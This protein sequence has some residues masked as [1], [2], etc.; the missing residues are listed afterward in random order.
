M[1]GDAD[2][3]QKSRYSNGRMSVLALKEGY[4]DAAQTT[5]ESVG[6]GRQQGETCVGKDG[7]IPDMECS[8]YKRRNRV[9]RLSR[10]HQ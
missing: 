10:N 1:K 7:D 4:G 6:V 9:N 2:N 5:S 8:R 3:A